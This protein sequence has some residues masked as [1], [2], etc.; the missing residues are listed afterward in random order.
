[1][2]TP[3]YAVYPAIPASPHSLPLAPPVDDPSFLCPFVYPDDPPLTIYP[4]TEPYALPGTLV[5]QGFAKYVY[6]TYLFCY[7]WEPITNPVYLPESWEEALNR[8]LYG[9]WGELRQMSWGGYLLEYSEGT[10]LPGW[11]PN[12]SDE[13]ERETNVIDLPWRCI[14][15]DTEYYGTPAHYYFGMSDLYEVITTSWFYHTKIASPNADRGVSVIPL[16]APLLLL[17]PGITSALISSISASNGGSSG[18]GRRRH[19]KS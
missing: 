3:P 19:K 5:G 17:L 2:F 16:L 13:S 4:V 15:Y 9:A 6:A 1:M 8:G 7:W 10:S 14:T 18:A 11:E 12:L